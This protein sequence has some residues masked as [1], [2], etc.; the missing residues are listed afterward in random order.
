MRPIHTSKSRKISEE[1]CPND[2]VS[3]ILEQSNPYI[4]SF[5]PVTHP[6]STA[7]KGTKEGADTLEYR[8]NDFN[9]PFSKKIML[10]TKKMTI[11]TNLLQKL[12]ITFQK[13]NIFRCGFLQCFN[14]TISNNGANF[15][16]NPFFYLCKGRYPL[17]NTLESLLCDH[18][19]CCKFCVLL[20][21]DCTI[22]I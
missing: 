17:C 11:F 15:K 9:F 3:R 5:Q 8:I 12:D 4:N 10:F 20:S 1:A 6:L 19:C 16:Q 7:F 14:E 21:C 2:T 22:Y 13:L 18:Y